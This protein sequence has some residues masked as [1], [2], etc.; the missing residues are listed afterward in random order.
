M[1]KEDIDHIVQLIIKRMNEDFRTICDTRINHS[2]HDYVRLTIS[3]MV[4]SS[5]EFKL[6]LQDFFSNEAKRMIQEEMENITFPL[7]VSQL[8]A[9]TG[10][11]KAAL[12][13]R[14]HRGQLNFNVSG[15]RIFISVRELN[16][17]LL[18]NHVKRAKKNQQKPIM[19]PP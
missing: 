7:T 5:D 3:E 14:R 19:D 4:F 6:L 15:G 11:S 8:S 10:I 16:N 13:Q 9:L 17:Q 2:L 18:N 12:Y 1:K